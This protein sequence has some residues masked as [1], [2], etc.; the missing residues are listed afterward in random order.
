MELLE[1]I[2]RSG[3]ISEA[4]RRMRMSYRHAWLLVQG[5]NEG[6]G[7]PLVTAATGGK[8]GGGAMLTARGR[9]AVDTF[10]DLREQVRRTAASVAPRLTSDGVERSVHVAAAVSLEE[11]LEQLLADYAL[12]CTRRSGTDRL[13]S[14]G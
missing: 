7:E 8:R 2:D 13:R 4:A 11:V 9:W 14:L 3:S 5:M 10:R 1:A 6:A 12:W